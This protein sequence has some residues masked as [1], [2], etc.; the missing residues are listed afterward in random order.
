MTNL[1]IKGHAT[2]GKEVIEILEMLGGE[3]YFKFTGSDTTCDYRIET[4]TNRIRLYIYKDKDILKFTLE[5][6]WEK[7]PYKVGDKVIWKLDKDKTQSTITR[8]S[9]GGNGGVVYWLNCEGSSFG[10]CD[11][12]ELEPYKEETME[13]KKDITLAPDLKG[14]DYSGRRIGY[15]IPNGYECECVTKN[16]IILKPIKPQYPKNYK[17]CC[18]ILGYKASYD[19]NNITTHDCVYDYKL[20]MLY[21]VL[22]CRDAYWK[23]AGEEMG[24]KESWKPDWSDYENI[25][26]SIKCRSGEIFYNQGY[27]NHKI[28]AFP[29]KEMR[30]IFLENFKDL[31]EKCKELL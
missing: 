8:V 24:L 1:A 3:N 20:Q 16:E 26:Y 29:T 31:I 23:I 19:L 17:E 7:Y 12:N 13:E 6:F 21:K 4:E 30:D 14:E 27:H 22:I 10:W 2:R 11:V 25:K 18:D 15:K 28:L 9:W 5:E